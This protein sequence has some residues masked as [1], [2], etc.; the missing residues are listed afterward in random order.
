MKAMFTLY[1][2]VIARARKPYRRGFLFPHKNSYFG[3]I[4]VTERSSTAPI[5]KVVSH[6]SDWCS[7]YP[8]DSCSCRQEKLSGEYS[9]SLLLFLNFT[10][11]IVNSIKKN[12]I[13]NWIKYKQCID[14]GSRIEAT[15]RGFRCSEASLHQLW[16]A[17]N[18]PSSVK[19]Y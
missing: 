14:P 15:S 11:I 12:V 9:Q 2:T 10:T 19:H 4:S 17:E 18:L 5:S 13:W 6:V 7:Y 16:A 1:G 3:A 8:A